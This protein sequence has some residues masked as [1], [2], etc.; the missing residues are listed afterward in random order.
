MIS[1]RTLWLFVL[2]GAGTF[3]LLFLGAGFRQGWFQPSTSFRVRFARGDG[4]YVGTPVS[5]AGLKA[6]QVAAVELD[7][8]NKVSVVLRIQSAFANKIKSDSKASLGRPFIIGE[9]LVS[10]SPG[11]P[12]LPTLPEGSELQGEEVLEITDLLSG[13]RLAPYFN[14]FTK[15]MDQLQIVIEGDGSP[16][17]VPLS[18]LYKQAH[19]TLKAV[20]VAGKDLTA[21]KTNFVLSPDLQKILRELAAGSP[22]IAPVLAGAE[23]SLPELTRI[24]NEFSVL[25]PQ[26]SKTMNE[27]VFTLQAAQRSFVLSGGVERLKWEETKKAKEGAKGGDAREPASPRD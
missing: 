2:L 1:K 11:S 25:V 26:L 8:D 13:G 7:H 6:G 16:N 10:I 3:A 19:R 18:E 14:T 21:I 15:L 24:A 5:I 12:A 23:R 22:H 9:R 27:A 20:E 4:V 17:A